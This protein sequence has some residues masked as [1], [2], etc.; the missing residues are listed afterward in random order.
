MDVGDRVDIDSNAYVVLEMN[1]M[2]TTFRRTD[3]KWVFISNN[4]LNTKV[5]ENVRRSGATSE[6]FS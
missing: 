6:T 1:L 4:L 2:S 5:I 3:G